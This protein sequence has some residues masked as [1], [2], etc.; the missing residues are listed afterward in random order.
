MRFSARWVLPVLAVAVAGGFNA[1]AAP[2]DGDDGSGPPIV[3]P[4]GSSGSQSTSSSGSGSSGG[5][6]SGTG[7]TDATLIGN[8]D[9]PSSSDDAGDAGEAGDDAGEAGD[10]AGP[11]SA[12]CAAGQT[13]VDMVPA[14]WTGYVQLLV[15]AADA[16]VAALDA[17]ATCTLP[18]GT[19]QG[20]GITNPT[21]PAADC[22]SCNCLAG[23]AGPIQCSVGIATENLLCI[24]PT[25]PTSPAVQNT[26]VGVS[27]A[28]GSASAPTVTA[29]SGTCAPASALAQPST[30]SAVA[31][32]LT[33]DAGVPDA[34]SAPGP[35]CDTAQACAIPVVG[36][37][38]SPGGICIYQSGIVDC[39]PGHFSDQHVVGASLDD[40]RGCSCECV[41][42]SCP[43]D[44]YITGYASSDCSGT[45]AFTF[46]AGTACKVGV[47]VHGSTSFIYHPSHG[48]FNG[49]CAAV[50]AGPSGAVAV[51][52]TGATTYCCIP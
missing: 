33:G 3:S 14:G 32:A 39:P 29:S 27:G 9:A 25:G 42:P 52:A 31:C 11:A 18:Y 10:D 49:M 34:G 43:A 51:D 8:D 7:T 50:D 16:G 17:G 30:S 28:N 19:P 15:G 44:G 5:S 35:V 13:C 48:T 38:G 6:S 36:P 22:S 20:T 46:D 1:C 45:A 4:G 41:N 26:C 47:N 2:G 24:P 21:G 23:D 37:A 12:P 40:G